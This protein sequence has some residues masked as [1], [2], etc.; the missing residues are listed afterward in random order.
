MMLVSPTV[1]PD[2]FTLQYVR[3]G[4]EWVRLRRKVKGVQ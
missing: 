3:G 4:C 1:T 2:E